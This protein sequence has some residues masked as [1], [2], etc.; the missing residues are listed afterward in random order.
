LIKVL[1]RK[2]SINVQKVMWIASELNIEMVRED[3]GGAFGGNNTQA[4]LA[5]NPNGRIPTLIDGNEVVWESNAIVR[6]LAEKAGKTPWYPSNL[7]ARARA[8]QWMD[9]Y[10]SSMH[11]PMTVIFWQLVRTAPENRDKSAFDKAVLEASALWKIVD[12]ALAS[13]PFLAGDEPDMG[14]VPLGCSAYRWNMLDFDK[15]ELPNIK[16]YFERLSARKA[17][18]ANVM[19]PLT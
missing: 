13:S 5:M 4:Y 9:F 8:N 14:D 2:N 11:P 15:P 6:Y 1:G 3:V 18:Q 7:A 16:A 12:S 19:I 10:L 17:Y